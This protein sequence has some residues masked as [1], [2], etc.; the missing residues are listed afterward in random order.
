MTT[1]KVKIETKF[2]GQALDRHVDHLYA[3]RGSRIVGIVELAHIDRTQ[4]TAEAAKDPIVVC[5]IT[6]L[7]IA[8]PDQEESLRDAQRALYL[9]RTARGT[10][11]EDNEIQ[12]PD[13]IVEDCAGLLGAIEN[14]RLRAG[15]VHL[16]NTLSTLQTAPSK[17]TS[18]EFRSHIDKT[19]KGLQALLDGATETEFG[20]TR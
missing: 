9:Q 15:L 10:L 1:T 16:L 18:A 2:N 5:R 14:A 12:L 8:N 7:E 20:E 3:N 6:A 19:T 13:S 17:T 4:P 11:D